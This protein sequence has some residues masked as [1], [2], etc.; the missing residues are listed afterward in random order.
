MTGLEKSDL[1]IE[2][3]ACAGLTVYVVSKLIFIKK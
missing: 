3:T 2:V 1:L